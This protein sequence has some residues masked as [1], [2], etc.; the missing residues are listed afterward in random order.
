MNILLVDVDTII[1]NLALCKLKKYYEDQGHTVALI[2][3]NKSV[4]PLNLEDYDKIYVSCIFDYHKNQ[5]KKWEG[6]AEIGGSGYSIEKKL[7]DE[8]ENVK[9]RINQG[10]T[11]RG[12]C[13]ACEFCIVNRKEGK[14]KIIGDIYDIWDGESPDLVIM[15]NNI[16][17]IPSHFKKIAKQ[18]RKEKLTVDFNSGFDF[19]LLTDDI[20]QDMF[21][22]KQY[23]GN[24]KLAFDHISYRRGVLKALKMLRKNGLKDWCSRWYV[25]VGTYDTFET[26][27]QRVNLLREH[28]QLAFVM[29]DRKVAAKSYPL[30]KEFHELYCY[31]SSPQI[32]CTTP[33][34]PGVMKN[35]SAKKHKG[36]KPLLEL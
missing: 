34:Y 8:I 16:L 10:F 26:V 25:Y 19:R 15:D 35:K 4:L 29:R 22:V 18:C 9:P 17:S 21:S 27:I 28:K 3:D 2:K 14:P 1:P 32:F 12:C 11:M 24:V 13:R 23:C 30:W 20:C 36:M 6:I 7:P 33:Y 31:S 5:C